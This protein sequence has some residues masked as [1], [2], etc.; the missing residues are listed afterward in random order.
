[1]ENLENSRNLK[2]CQN[3]K[4]NSGKFEFLQKNLEK[5]GKRIVCDKIT[6]EMYSSMNFSLLSYSEKIENLT[7]RTVASGSPQT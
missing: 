3:L 5:S 1:M 4:E 7:T 6:N 2:N